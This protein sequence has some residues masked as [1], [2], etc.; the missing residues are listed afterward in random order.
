MHP[1]RA[2]LAIFA[3][4]VLAPAAPESVQWQL[5]QAG[6]ELA[7][8]GAR[9]PLYVVRIDP[10]HAQLQAALASA[11]SGQKRTAAEW[12]RNKNL[13]VAINLGMFQS[14][15]RSNVGYLRSAQHVN[16]GRWNAYRSV[17]AVNP[18]DAAKPPL[19]WRDLDQNSA[20]GDLAGYDLVVQNLR[21][22]AGQR[23]NV[24]A[25]SEKRWSEAAIAVDSHQRLLF[26]FTRTPHTM[27]DFNARVLGLPLD[28]ISAMHVE[29]GP[30]A[31][32]SIHTATVNL[33]LCG[34]YETGFLND[35]SNRQQWPIPNVLGVSR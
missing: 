25:A 35:D 23:R 18:K 32:L 8:I 22:I 16:N 28:V 3:V 17:L 26:L 20:T 24:W 7:V 13:A 30:E 29:G 31:S 33:D 27:R 15:Q 2:A 19:V 14:D 21:L 5:L 11:E 9:D 4:L 12:C 34:S 1:R 10:A 6:V